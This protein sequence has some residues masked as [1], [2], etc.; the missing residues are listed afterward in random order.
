MNNNEALAEAAIRAGCRFFAG[1][2]ITPATEILEHMARRM[3]EVGGI[4]LQPESEVSGMN[5]VCGAAAGGA[6]SMTASSG[7]GFDLFMEGIS[8]IAGWE[9]PCVV[10]VMSRSGPGRAG[11]GP[12]GSDYFQCCKGGGHGD[13]G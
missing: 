8:A 5:M 12:A 6:R 10:V 11:M 4:C 7:E 2:P 1:Y 3:P 9:I 13:S